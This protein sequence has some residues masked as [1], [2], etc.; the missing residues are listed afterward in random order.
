MGGEMTTRSKGWHQLLLWCFSAAAT[1][2]VV[3]LSVTA[4][5]LSID[6]QISYMIAN[7]SDIGSWATD[8]ATLKTSDVQKPFYHLYQFLWSRLFGLSEYS[9]RIAN[10]PWLFIAIGV[11]AFTFRRLPLLGASI[12]LTTAC[13]PL[14]WFYMNDA[15]PYAMMYASTMICCAATYGILNPNLAHYSGIE[16]RWNLV[17]L[18][19]GIV[20]LSSV[21]ML[22]VFWAGIFFLLISWNWWSV[23]TR[24]KLDSLDI[25]IL[26]VFLI[27][28]M[29]LGAI[30]LFSLVHGAGA[31]QL[32]ETNIL[33]MAFS[34]YEVLGLGGLGPS[35]DEI[36]VYGLAAFNDH[37]LRIVLFGTIIVSFLM[38]A[39]GE[40]VK[41]LGPRRV[42][43]LS[44]LFLLPLIITLIAGYLMHWRVLGRHI[45]P[46][47]VLIS[48]VSAFGIYRALSQRTIIA[49]IAA[50]AFASSLI[51]SS[52]GYTTTRHAK[53]DFSLAATLASNYSSAGYTV[54]WTA[55][56]PSAIH[57]GLD[58]TLKERDYQC[59]EPIKAGTV[60]VVRN[61]SNDCLNT[62]A[63]P[64]FVFYSRPDANDQQ[65][66]I[67]ALLSDRDFDIQQSF[68][69]FRVWLRPDLE[70]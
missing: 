55:N 5:S 29:M 8:L 9:M 34:A 2:I 30:Y 54:W 16:L 40:V 41:R 25:G 68:P 31:T 58:V 18:C 13:H 43:V 61:L 21:S 56:A 62:L 6:E 14:L 35:R 70:Q 38:F 4:E 20:L 11:T 47:T 36:R 39:T 51:Y 33:T 26:L 3:N 19:S 66:T 59:A 64:D 42:L 50:A 48:Y 7:K 52:I 15:Q 65:G 32:H 10:A 24:Q 44:C 46:V 1:L 28:M 22:G 63:N 12:I 45:I 69:G 60:L 49:L 27:V 57:Y 23:P 53:E 37:W 17:L 67:S